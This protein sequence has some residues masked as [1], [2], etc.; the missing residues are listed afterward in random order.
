[1]VHRGIPPPCK[2]LL[3]MVRFAGGAVQQAQH[4]TAGTAWHSEGK[5]QAGPAA[6]NP[7]QSFPCT[8]SGWP[9]QRHI[10]LIWQ[11][12]T[13]LAASR[14]APSAQ[15]FQFVMAPL[16]ACQPFV[17]SYAYSTAL[18][19]LWLGRHMRHA[20][21]WLLAA[22]LVLYAGP[23]VTLF[24]KEVQER[25][26]FAARRAAERRGGPAGQAELDAASPVGSPRA[27]VAASASSSGFDVAK[28]RARIDAEPWAPAEF[29]LPAMLGAC[30]ACL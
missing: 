28:L 15:I 27:S 13:C 10:S 9:S 23:L 8:S 17:H 12:H 5:Y 29:L 22:L 24:R 16:V 21:G 14:P 3:M 6:S 30:S 18:L 26:T 11:L 4:G 25:C 2:L 1:M 20:S 19:A 7:Q